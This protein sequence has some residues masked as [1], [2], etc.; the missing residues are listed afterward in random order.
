MTTL[1][2]RIEVVD[3]TAYL[4]DF[5]ETA[6]LMSC[7]DLVITVD[8][9]VAH[10]A[11]ALGRPTLV[12]LPYAPDYRWLLDREDSPWYPSMRLFRQDTRRDYAGVV[13]RVRSELTAMNARL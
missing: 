10:L 11:G 9:S 6:A 5:V 2:E 3:L 8:T 4:T 7:L 1:R 13:G 12:L